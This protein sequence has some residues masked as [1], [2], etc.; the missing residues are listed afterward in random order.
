MKQQ[1]KRAYLF[2]GWNREYADNKELYFPKMMKF[3]R[4][5]TLKMLRSSAPIKVLGSYETEW[6]DTAKESS[7]FRVTVIPFASVKEADEQLISRLL[8]VSVLLTRIDAGSDTEIVAFG[9]PESI[10]VG[11]IR[12][13][14]WC[15]QNLGIERIDLNEIQRE[16]IKS[17]KSG[18]QRILP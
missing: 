10:I 18:R 13:V 6:T 15:I 1:I 17:I 12:N 8:Y 14:Y 11:R 2:D 4:N 16:L 3:Q 7:R 9:L 5:K